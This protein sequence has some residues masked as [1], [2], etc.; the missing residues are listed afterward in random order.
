[1]RALP[2]D[3]FTG[4]VTDAKRSIVEVCSA[5]QDKNSLVEGASL[6]EDLRSL[7]EVSQEEDPGAAGWRRA[8]GW[9]INAQKWRRIPFNASGRD[10]DA[11]RLCHR[12]F[13]PCRG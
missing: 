12:R 6:A 4:A 5:N 8:I 11:S 3:E 1:M 7:V 9:R 13:V 2:S 10:S